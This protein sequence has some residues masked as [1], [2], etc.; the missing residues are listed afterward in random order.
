MSLFAELKRRNVIRMAGLYLVGAWLIV[1]VAG[2][3]FPMFGAPEWLPRSIVVLLALGFVPALV[4]SWV[5]ELTPEGL[6][7]DAD[8][9]LDQSV[10][11]HT[12][13]RMDRLIVVGLVAVI[14]LLVA[15]RFWPVAA[16]KETVSVASVPNAQTRTIAVLPFINLS[17][18]PD[19]EFFSDGITEEILNV[20]AGIEAFTVTSRTSSF[21]F[22]GK[23]KPLPEI[24]RELRVDYVLEGSVRKAGQQVRITAQLIKVDGDAHLWSESWTR[25]LA[26]I[27]AVQEGIA[28]NVANELE[29][30]LSP[31]DEAR[32]TR[33]GTHN[34]E[35]YEQYLRGRQL[36]N[37]RSVASL[38]SAVEAFEAA[39]AADPDYADAWAGL[40][41][42]YAVIPEYAA[43]SSGERH[44]SDATAKA[45]EAAHRALALDPDS[46]RALSARAYVRVMYE[47][48]WA[49]AED[50]YR[51]AIDYDPRD[52]GTR[53]W[54]GELLAYQRRWKESAVQYEA[55]LALDPLAPVIHQSRGALTL[56]AGDPA[57]ALADFEASSTLAPGFSFSAYMKTLALIDLRRFDDAIAVARALPDADREMMLSIIAALQ[58]PSRSNEALRRIMAHGRDA[59]PGRPQLLALVGRP[60]LALPELERLFA[61]EDPYR[62]FLYDMSVF[63]PLYDDPRFE[64]LL[65]RIGL[66]NSNSGD[67]TSR[68]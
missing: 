2:T 29:A 30:R 63:E 59:I 18:D 12:G 14:A 43:F 11:A 36:W 7:R 37:Q 5:Y 17:G 33:A 46:S 48:D 26:D 65:R 25:D 27:F 55:A 6:K 38:D 44:A 20:L 66:P 45:H 1:Q 28:R 61:A 32:L 51:T 41:Q 54:Y 50:D 53:Q 4:F 58:D 22:K 15:D 31:R 16:R 3:V 56:F 62:V 21:H 8:V 34:V 9:P 57:A 13:R 68:P 35:A 40:A 64:A 47:F 23:D 42:T 39:L 67:R 60:D 24:A 52:A 19:Q 10:G 49:G